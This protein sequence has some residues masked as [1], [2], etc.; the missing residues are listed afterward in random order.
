MADETNDLQK[1]LS[2]FL[3]TRRAPAQP[4]PEKS[5]PLKNELSSFLSTQRAKM[6]PAPT[7]GLG[8]AQRISIAPPPPALPTG[9]SEE[10]KAFLQRHPQY[11]TTGMGK[12]PYLGAQSWWL[13]TANKIAV[14]PFNRID[15]WI[16]EADAKKK[17]HEEQQRFE[18]YQYFDKQKG[19]Q[20]SLEE[21]ARLHPLTAT[22]RIS[23]AIV[24]KAMNTVQH[25]ALDPRNLVLMFAGE[26]AGV[27]GLKGAA[28]MFRTAADAGFAGLQGYGAYEGGKNAVAKFQNKD[29]EGGITDLMGSVVDGA[30][31]GMGVLGTYGKVRSIG[32]LNTLDAL[33]KKTYGRDW[34]DLPQAQRTEISDRVLQANA[35]RAPILEELNRA[36]N[37]RDLA[38]VKKAYS[39]LTGVPFSELAKDLPRGVKPG[40]EERVA[41]KIKQMQD[42]YLEHML[43]LA[44]T[45]RERVKTEWEKATDPAE[46]Q[47]ALADLQ[48][49]PAEETGKFSD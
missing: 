2:Q 5:Q 6:A 33:S 13:A 41:S 37:N 25:V 21:E 42:A 11:D 44:E 8:P 19:R 28:G 43:G 24:D 7:A 4:K 36:E 39:R 23:N 1:Q 10:D 18:M 30:F 34:V 3:T 22:Q 47:K 17:Q 35:R 16:D 49:I 40:P 45:P 46:R 12:D 14:E 38:A 20:V 31:A 26:P 15:R 29:Y 48:K 27:E 9:I 32:T